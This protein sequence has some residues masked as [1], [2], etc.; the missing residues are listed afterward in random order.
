MPTTRILA[1]SRALKLLSTS[2]HSMVSR[3]HM[4]DAIKVLLILLVLITIQHLTI[5]INFMQVH[6]VS[7]Q[8]TT[9][10]RRQ[11][12]SYILPP[13]CTL[14]MLN[15]L[16]VTTSDEYKQT[17]TPCTM[18]ISH[19]IY[20]EFFVCLTSKHLVKISQ[21]YCSSICSLDN[22]LHNLRS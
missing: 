13:R 19:T 6:K 8:P 2:P 3:A 22:W 14:R 5:I 20:R 4:H 10:V 17:A 18:H 16:F 9:A 1:T 21:P 12:T 11:V 7:M 15:L